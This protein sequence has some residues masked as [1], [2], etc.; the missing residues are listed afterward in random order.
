MPSSIQPP[1]SLRPARSPRPSKR[2]LPSPAFGNRPLLGVPRSRRPRLVIIT[3]L[4][5]YKPITLLPA[6]DY[7]RWHPTTVIFEY[8]HIRGIDIPKIRIHERNSPRIPKPLLDLCKWFNNA[9][10]EDCI[11][12]STVW[13]THLNRVEWLKYYWDVASTELVIK[14]WEWQKKIRELKV[15]KEIKPGEREEEGEEGEKEREERE[16]EQAKRE[17]EREKEGKGRE[18]RVKCL[19][20]LVEDGLDIDVDEEVRDDGSDGNELTEW[21]ESTVNAKGEDDPEGLTQEQWELVKEI[22]ETFE[23]EERGLTAEDVA[24]HRR[25]KELMQGCWV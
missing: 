4:I 5:D 6:P 7:Q 8:M 17:E 16:K 13:K 15:P 21:R 9:T 20:A 1:A 22:E 23:V 14:F 10:E 12:E 24:V 11:R 18:K 25:L 3:K 19:D 2:K